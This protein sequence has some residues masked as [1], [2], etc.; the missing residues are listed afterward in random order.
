MNNFVEVTDQ[1]WK[2]DVEEKDGEVE[3]EKKISPYTKQLVPRKRNTV[4]ILGPQNSKISDKRTETLTKHDSVP[5][6][7]G[8]SLNHA[9]VNHVFLYIMEIIEK[10]RLKYYYRVYF[11]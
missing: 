5:S 1:I 9:R 6:Y 7:F 2:R 8:Y 11:R 10:L 4:W 3:C